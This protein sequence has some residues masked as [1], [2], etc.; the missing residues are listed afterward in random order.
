MDQSSASQIPD[1]TGHCR[2]PANDLQ[3][4]ALPAGHCLRQCSLFQREGDEEICGQTWDQTGLPTSTRK[5]IRR[6]DREKPWWVTEC[7][8]RFDWTE[9]RQTMG[10]LIPDACYMTNARPYSD[11]SRLCPLD[12][13]YSGSQLP[14]PED[15]Q[16]DTT[17]LLGK[18]EMSH[19]LPGTPAATELPAYH[20]R[21]MAKRRRCLQ[22]Y[23]YYY[24]KRRRQIR[25]RLL[26]G[27]RD[28]SSLFPVDSWVHVHREHPRSKIGRKWSEQRKIVSIPSASTRLVERSDGMRSLEW[29]ANLQAASGAPAE[30]S[31]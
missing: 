19:L 22:K 3:L 9:P 8:S 4:H 25:T 21:Q 11:E 1:G 12:L 15:L 31:E 6:L 26:K 20:G 10:Q 7:S 14:D 23:E 30:C 27:Y 2:R 18:V 5:C 17:G 16:H 13:I 28:L 24:N 29:I